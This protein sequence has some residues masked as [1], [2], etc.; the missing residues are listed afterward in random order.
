MQQAVISMFESLSNR[1]A[2]GLRAHCTVDISLYEYG[3]AW[4][5][6]TLINKAITMNTAADF[7][8]NN[9]FDFITT[10]VAKNTSWA[11]Y[12]LNSAITRDGKQVTMEWLETVF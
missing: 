6:D 1:D 12:R 5:I 10:E 4:N 9:S 3:Q 2:A 7:K 11:T 8:R